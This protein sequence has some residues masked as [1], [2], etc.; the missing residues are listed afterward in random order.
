MSSAQPSPRPTGSQA[1]FL[2]KCLQEAAPNGSGQVRGSWGSKPSTAV[3]ALAA[4][5]LPQAIQ[6]SNS[7]GF[8]TPNPL[9]PQQRA[10]MPSAPICSH[11]PVE[12]LS[13]PAP[14]TTCRAC[15]RSQWWTLTP[16]TLG[17]C[18]FCHPPTSNHLIHWYGTARIAAVPSNAP[19]Q[20]TP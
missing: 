10:G 20:V 9:L 15:H 2:D 16:G 11:E 7:E 5:K 1:S 4:P 13:A 14:L 3:A 8:P 18:A 12:D 17:T 19:R 6:G